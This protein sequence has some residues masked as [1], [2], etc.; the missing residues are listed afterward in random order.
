MNDTD[1]I[2]CVECGKFVPYNEMKDGAIFYHEP[3][4]EYGPE[5]NEW[6]CHRCILRGQLKGWEAALGG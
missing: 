4:N 1:P 6:T 3:D 5:V 2:K